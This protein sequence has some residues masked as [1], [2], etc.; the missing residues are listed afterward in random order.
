[1]VNKIIENISKVIVGKEDVCKLLL[2]SMV[3]GGHVLIEDM[4]GSGKTKLAKALGKTLDIKFSRIQFTPDLLPSDVT[5][6]NVF[7]K[8]TSEFELKKGPVFTNILLADE[9]NRAT[10]RTQAG[11]LECMEEHQVTIDGETFSFPEP[12][13]VIATQNPIETAGTFPLPEAQLDRFLMKISMG[14]LSREDEMSI[15]DRFEGED[16]LDTL[17][18]VATGSDILE[19]RN[20][21]KEVFVSPDVKKYILD[22]IEKTR[23]SERVLAGV[24]TRGALGLMNAAK[25]YAVVLGR[26]YVIPDDINYLSKYVLAHRLVLSTG[27]SNYEEA[28]KIIDRIVDATE[29]PTEKVKA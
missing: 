19:L 18:N 14:A 11:L 10:P 8:A 16:P 4:P 7:N 15:L 13:F 23:D 28:K 21:A 17:G 2:T 12:F 26:D 5:G 6:L 9:I 24:S 3:A 25:A 1:M 22:I 29:K 20:K 27:Q